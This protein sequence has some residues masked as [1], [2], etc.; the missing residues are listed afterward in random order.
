[1][2]RLKEQR[3]YDAFKKLKPKS[4]KL[5]RVENMVHDGTPDVLIKVPGAFVFLELKSPI[6]PK[7]KTT[8]LLGTEGL[9]QSQK[10]WFCEAECLNLP[11]YILIRDSNN[12]VYL[13][14]GATADFVNELNEEDLR[15]E[16]L[17]TSLEGAYE[18][19]IENHSNESPRA[20]HK[21]SL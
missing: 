10:N 12:N 1:M 8:R 20:R 5:E 18:V 13:V 21:P 11:A 16:S 2:A 7:R 6:A 4:V 3:L 14:E 15:A 19:I 9:R 17:A